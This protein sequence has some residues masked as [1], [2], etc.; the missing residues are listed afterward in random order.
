MHVLLL[1]SDVIV[2]VIGM[3]AVVAVLRAAGNLKRKFPDAKED[4]L[5]LRAI[6]DVRALATLINECFLHPLHDSSRF[7]CPSMECLS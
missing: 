5:M 6:K 2:A 1:I 4:M 3:R 7:C